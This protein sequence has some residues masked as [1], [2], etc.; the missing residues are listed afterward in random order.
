MICVIPTD[1]A[2]SAPAS[3]G[4]TVLASGAA[5]PL[6]IPDTLTPSSC[7]TVTKP[8]VP[9]TWAHIIARLHRNDEMNRTISHT[10]R[11][12]D[13]SGLFDAIEKWSTIRAA[14]P[15]NQTINNELWSGCFAYPTLFAVQV[16]FRNFIFG[17]GQENATKMYKLILG[18]IGKMIDLLTSTHNTNNI[19]KHKTDATHSSQNLVEPWDWYGVNSGS[20]CHFSNSSNERRK[21]SE[22]SINQGTNLNNKGLLCNAWIKIVEQCKLNNSKNINHSNIYFYT[23]MAWDLWKILKIK[24]HCLLFKLLRS[25]IRIYK[26]NVFAIRIF[27]KMKHIKTIWK[28]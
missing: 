18:S 1:R 4:D 16:V 24:L 8:D 20:R 11:N 28:D 15:E 13:H 5:T 21:G 6:H 12:D 17:F 22:R 2:D 14:Y 23:A 3:A 7:V 19:T 10:S 26:N 9:E 27:L 25:F